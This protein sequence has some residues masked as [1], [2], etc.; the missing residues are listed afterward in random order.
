MQREKEYLAAR[1]ITG[2]RCETSGE[3]P[4][5]D[6]NGDVKKILALKTRVLPSGKF[7]SDDS[8]EFSGSV[9]YDVVYLDSENNVTHAEFVTDYD[10]AIKIN[11]ESFVDADVDTSVSACS[12]RL[13]GPRKISAKCSLESDVRISERRAVSIDGD[14]FAAF[15]PEILTETVRVSRFV[16][17]STEPR[18]MTEQMLSLDG[19]IAD[20]VEVLFTDACVEVEHTD[21]TP[22]GVDV[23]AK[24]ALSMLWRDADGKVSLLT[25]DVPISD[26]IPCDTAKFDQ[27]VFV[28]GETVSQ[29]GGV[30]PTDEGVNLNTSL[31]VVFKMYDVS[32]CDIDLVKDSYLKE[33]GSENEYSDFSYTEHIASVRGE[34][35][36]AYRTELS[37]TGIEC[38]D[39][40]VYMDAKVHVSSSDVTDSGVK[41]VGEIRF[42]GIASQ[43]FEENTIT[44]T[45]IKF[46]APISYNVNLDCQKHDNMRVNCNVDANDIKIEC[47]ENTLSVTCTLSTFLTVNSERRQRCLGASY[48]TDEEFERDESTVTVY[49]PDRSETLFDIAKRFHTSVNAIAAANKLTQ[50]VFAA[51]NEPI[52]V[53]DVKKLVIR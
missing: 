8:L 41:I 50:S 51:A 53:S 24:I 29:K 14:A 47:D 20:E 19:A 13:I 23:K 35:D 27:N 52:G 40:I 16:F 17:A 22:S 6:Y 32:N 5:P 39:E 28:R 45:P 37:E 4:L 11:S 48:L 21:V 38:F 15:E 44:Y 34:N 46:T 31:T 3:Y 9:G 7:A 2:L 42:S 26:T 25:K 43:V 12:I 18:E 36:F 49:Y 33:R 30:I 1:E 10:A